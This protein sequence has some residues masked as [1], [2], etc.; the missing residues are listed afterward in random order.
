MHIELDGRRVNIATGGVEPDR[1]LP[2]VLLVHG[3]G[4]D[5]TVWNLQ[6]RFLAHHGCAAMAVDLPGHGGSDGPLIATVAEMAE[7]VGQLIDELDWGSVRLVGHSMGALISMEVAAGRS[8]IERLVL[9]GAAMSMAVH[10]DLLGAAERNEVLAPQLM[11]A[12]GHG[13]RSHVVTNPTPGLWMVGGGQALLERAAPGVIA[14]DLA[15]CNTYDA[16]DVASRVECPVTV[17]VG[18]ADRMTPPRAAAALIA[19]FSDVE[20]VHLDGVGHS[21]MT[22]APDAIRPAL[23]AALA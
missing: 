8:D 6:T 16:G 3:A 10:P 13:S 2:L 11:T 4:M 14:S 19:G 17:M 1:D 23:Q 12:W 7:W 18:S 22:E 9:M 21:M 5:R 20:V 15:A